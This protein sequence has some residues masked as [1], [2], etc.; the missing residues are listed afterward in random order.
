MHPHVAYVMS[1]A[2]SHIDD[3][4]F[5]QSTF[6]G[7]HDVFSDVHSVDSI[8]NFLANGYTFDKYSPP[9]TKY[10]KK[11]SIFD[12]IGTADRNNTLKAWFPSITV[13]KKVGDGWRSKQIAT[14]SEILRIGSLIQRMIDEKKEIK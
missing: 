8:M 7:G 5:E 9:A 4:T 3:N 12:A 10:S 11:Y 1:L 14:G 13:T 6:G 2:F